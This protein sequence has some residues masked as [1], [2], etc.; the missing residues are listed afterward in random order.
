MDFDFTKILLII[1]ILTGVLWVLDK[2]FLK[3]KRD[4][5]GPTPLHV[6]WGASFFPIFLIVFVLRS[7]IFEPFQIPSSSMVPTLEVGDFIVVNKFSY[8]VRLPIVGTKLIPVSDPQ[9]GDVAVFI[10]PNDPR[11]FIK[12]VVGLPGD[13]IRIENNQVWVNG[14]LLE[15]E[16]IATVSRFGSADVNLSEERMGEI[17]HSIHTHD[18][19]GKYGISGEFVVEDGHYFMMGDNRD[20][21]QDSREWGTVP[22]ANLVGQAKAIWMHW[23]NWGVPSFSRVGSIQ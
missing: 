21:S 22:D 7:F 2:L 15:Q 8:G 17:V 20:N 3:K 10:P 1:V 4:P 14:D 6:E 19:P 18:P 11:Y 9:R 13:R 16:F 12:R 5:D 23:E